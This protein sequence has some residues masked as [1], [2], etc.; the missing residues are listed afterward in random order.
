MLKKLRGDGTVII[1][2]SHWE[3]GQKLSDY[4]PVLKYADFFTPNDKEAMALT[5]TQ[6]AEEALRALSEYTKNPIVK[7]GKNGCIA[8]IGGEIMS[9]PTIKANTVDTTGAGD[10]F[11]TG[12]C[13]GI[14]HKLPLEQCIRLA[15]IAGA[16]STEACGC[17]EA[18]YDLNDWRE[19]L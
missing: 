14:Y 10:N 8:K 6:T 12:L 18:R 3:E 4:I 11:L 1:Y 2:D 19:N 16:L 17:F 9:F 5:E 13:Y 15:N 7:V